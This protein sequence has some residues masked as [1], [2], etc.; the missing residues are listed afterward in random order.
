MFVFV[1]VQLVIGEGIEGVL[2][3]LLLLRRGG[4]LAF[5]GFGFLRHVD[6]SGRGLG[7]ARQLGV[8]KQTAQM[9]LVAGGRWQAD[10]WKPCWTQCCGC[11]MP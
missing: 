8:V 1:K 5:A 6:F 7:L 11:A 9:H 3:L 4:L 10:V 2:T